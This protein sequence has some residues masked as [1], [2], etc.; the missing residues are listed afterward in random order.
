MRDGRSIVLNAS[1]AS[2]KRPP[3]SCL[4]SASRAAIRSFARTWTAGLKECSIRVNVL[5]AGHIDTPIFETGN[6]TKE[7]IGAWKAKASSSIPFGRL[8]R[9]EE[10]CESRALSD[11]ARQ[12]L[13]SR[14]RTLC[15]RW[16]GINIGCRVTRQAAH[17][18]ILLDSPF[19]PS[20]LGHEWE[21]M[22]SALPQTHCVKPP[23]ALPA[24]RSL[25]LH[26]WRKRGRG[27]LV[28]K[29][30]AASINISSGSG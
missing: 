2:I 20:H 21:A 28:P 13:R 29:F 25:A 10:G 23:E 19:M 1:L 15:G 11:L 18:N 8:G 9:P 30:R 24:R 7:E 5:S 14:R 16:Y 4:Y 3:T 22:L 6:H 26:H 27:G 17:H 12:Q